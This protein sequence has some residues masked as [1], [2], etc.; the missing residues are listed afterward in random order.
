M[1]PPLPDTG[2]SSL[3]YWFEMGILEKMTETAI[4]GGGRQE[5]REKRVSNGN[6]LIPNDGQ[7][8]KILSTLEKKKV[9]WE[10]QREGRNPDEEI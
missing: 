5:K 2:L 9:E 3:S 10:G 6:P 7:L 1:I 8:D 4:W